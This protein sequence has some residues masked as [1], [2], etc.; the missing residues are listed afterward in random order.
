MKFLIQRVQRAS[1]TVDNRV[2]GKIDNGFLVLK[3]S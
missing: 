3:I 2:V 1:V